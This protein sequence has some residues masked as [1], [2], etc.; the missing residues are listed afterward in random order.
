[1]GHVAPAGTAAIERVTASQWLHWL[2]A[3]R[4][5]FMRASNPI[6]RGESVEAYARRISALV[7]QMTTDALRDAPRPAGQLSFDDM[8]AQLERDPGNTG[9][10]S[11]SSGSNTSTPPLSQ[12]LIQGAAQVL[13]VAAQT[14]TAIIT[15]NNQTERT[16]LAAQ[17]QQRIAELQAQSNASNDRANQ[18]QQAMMAQLLAALGQRPAMSTGMII[19]IGV[20]AVVVVGGAMYFMGKRRNP[21]L[22]IPGPD[23]KRHRNYV[24]SARLR[25]MRNRGLI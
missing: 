12:Q 15:S 22:S 7:A 24:S 6:L 18:Q 14:I 2:D 4:R 23:G 16:R 19:G 5:A 3:Q 9:S 21:V 11:G 13:G 17:A 25:R 10:T 20:A 8:L 1:M